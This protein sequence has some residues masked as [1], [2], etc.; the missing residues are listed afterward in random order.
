[1]TKLIIAEKPS[2]ARAIAAGIGGNQQKDKTHIRAGEYIITWCFG[3]LLELKMPEDYNTSFKN[4]ADRPIPFIPDRWEYRPAKDKS[5][6]VSVIKKLSQSASVIINAGD[7]DREGSYLVD[8]LIRFIGFNGPVWRL[9]ISD[10]NEKAVQKALSRM[11]RFNSTENL[12]RSAECRSKAD[13]VYGLNLT[14]AYTLAAKKSGFNKVLS[15]GRVQTPVLGL[16]VKRKR[17]RDSFKPHPFYSVIATLEKGTEFQAKGRIESPESFCDSEG[18]LIEKSHAQ[19]FLNSATGKPAVISSIKKEESRSSAP[20]LFSLA[21]LQKHANAKLGMTASQVLSS[22]QELYE[23]GITTYPRTDCQYIT[24]E[25]WSDAER[26]LR[27]LAEF[28]PLSSATKADHKIKHSSVNNSKVGAHHAIIPTGNLSAVEQLADKT[29][30]LFCMIADRY[31]AIFYPDALDEKTQAEI[32][33]G[34]RTFVAKGVIQKREGW[35]VVLGQKPSDKVLPDLAQGEEVTVKAIS[36]SEK[37]TTPP[38]D[39]TEGSLIEAMTSIAKHVQDESLKSILKETDGLGTEATRAAIIEGLVKRGFIQ[40]VTKRVVPTE[41]GCQFVD[42][43]PDELSLPDMTARWEMQLK[44]ISNGEGSEIE[45]LNQL[46]E[47]VTRLSQ[48]ATVNIKESSSGFT[49]LLCKSADLKKVSKKNGGAFW[50][51]QN[52]CGY[53]CTDNRGKPAEKSIYKCPECGSRLARRN[54]D[55]G[56]WWGCTGFKTGCKYTAQDQKG[57][58]VE[59]GKGQTVEAE[60]K[61]CPDCNKPMR[62]RDGKFGKFWGCTGYPECKTTVK[63]Q[64]GSIG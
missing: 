16:L 62:L 45:F 33:I 20:R 7:P 27:S 52:D 40:R 8:S 9:L 35:R 39:Y 22:A 41:E 2:L 59:R 23:K 43:I 13:W 29:V 31:I 50:I 32:L 38:D 55:K 21:D 19:D 47:P 17:D 37:M 12:S 56:W 3:H 42:Q 46:I 49:C 14:T 36:L 51:C 5:S 54:G 57:K 15:V 64:H 18:R 24:D 11:D 60:Q 34:T 6:Q 63:H 44:E 25:L 28:K 53:S 61:C 1:M 10:V 48:S 26:T 58:P 30:K 4:W